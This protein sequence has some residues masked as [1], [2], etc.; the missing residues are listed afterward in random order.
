M[1]GDTVTAA[2]TTATFSDKNAGTGKTVTVSG[3]TIGGADAGNYVLADP[4]T[5]TTADITAR[6]LTVTAT[7][8]DRGYDGTTGATVSL[9]TSKLTGDA[10]TAS[11]TSATFADQERRGEQ[12][13]HRLWHHHRRS[14]CR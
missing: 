9:L 12:A 4:T 14:R 3:I 13:D 5:T 1:A 8:T 7:G 2:Y 11:Y 10:V 6:G